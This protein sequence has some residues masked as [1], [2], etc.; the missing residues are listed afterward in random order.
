MPGPGAP[1]ENSGSFLQHF[2]DALRELGLYERVHAA[3]DPEA[4][5]ALEKPQQHRWWP[6]TVLSRIVVTTEQVSDTETLQRSSYLAIKHGV[7]P[8]AMPLVK[9]TFALFG[10]SPHTIFSKAETYAPTAVRGL[11]LEWKHEGE[12][13]GTLIITYPIAVPPQYA[14]LWRGT[15]AFV[16]ELTK[17]TGTF[18]HVTH[19]ADGR[20]LLMPVSWT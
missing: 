17:V 14:T 20:R 13:S 8:I 5:S 19:E 4:R 16:F 18:G 12:R 11:L 2:A 15:L 3:L 9:V 10:P 6:G 7:A 1:F